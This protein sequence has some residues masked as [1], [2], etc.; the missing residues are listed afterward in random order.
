M[1]MHLQKGDTKPLSCPVLV[2]VVR[3]KFE[4]MN[5]NFLKTMN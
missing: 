1:T 3:V 2:I 4:K 5:V